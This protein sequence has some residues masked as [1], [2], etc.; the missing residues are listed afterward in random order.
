MRHAVSQLLRLAGLC[1]LCVISGLQ[2]FKVFAQSSSN[3]GHIEIQSASLRESATDWQLVALADIQL[4]PEMRQGL[5][6]GVPLQFI[7]DFRVKRNRNYWFDDTVLE[8]RHRY[9]LI[10]YELTRHYRLQSL[11]TGESGNYRSLIAALE[12][13][14]RLQNV[15]VRKPI[16]FDNN[17]SDNG[18]FERASDS[19]SVSKVSDSNGF[20]RF[21]SDVLGPDVVD[22]D[23]FAS[24]VN[25]QLYGQLSLRLDDKALP[26]PLRPLLSSTWKLASEDFAWSLN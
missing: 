22:S 15:V 17:G 10:Y 21:A 26:L 13:L 24:D 8:Y 7:V 6:S 12:I 19:E 25:T 18:A 1:A 3:Q 2:P 4:S 9:S 20:V 16:L 23:V 11:T 14:G 5:N